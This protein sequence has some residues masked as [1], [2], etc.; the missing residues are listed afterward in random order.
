[1]EALTSPL[2]GV[3]GFS[4]GRDLYRA[5][6]LCVSLS[7]FVY[8]TEGL[9]K[10]CHPKRQAMCTGNIYLPYPYRKCAKINLQRYASSDR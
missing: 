7:V 8:F 1:M 2:L 5:K 4:T 6:Y 9:F 10:F 3:N